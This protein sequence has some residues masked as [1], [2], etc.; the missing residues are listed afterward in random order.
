VVERLQGYAETSFEP[1]RSFLGE[2]DYQQQLDRWFRER[3]N[4]RF[5]RTL[6]CRPVDRLAEELQ[7][8]RPLPE[9]MPDVDRRFVTRIAPDPYVRIDG[10]DYSLDPRLVGRRVELRVSQQEILAVALATGEL[11]CRHVRSFARHRTLT[12]LEHARALTRPRGA[13]AE[14]E[15]ETRPARPLRPAD[16]GMS[17]SAELAF[18]FRTL[19][20]PAA[21]RAL[22]KLAERARQE[23]WS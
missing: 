13:P 22:P 11:A 2:L 3:A 12:A 15:V 6:R 14:P 18:L 17:S 23:E 21:A 10:T 8:M 5:H 4:V 9:R 20:A 19:K 7:L 1:G 16:P